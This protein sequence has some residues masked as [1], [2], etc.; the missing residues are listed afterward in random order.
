V[1]EQAEDEKKTGDVEETP[2]VS[3]DVSHNFYTYL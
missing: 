2:Q 3:T 1:A